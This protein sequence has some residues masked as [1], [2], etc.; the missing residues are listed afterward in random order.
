[1]EKIEKAIEQKK[2]MPKDMKKQV[3]RKMLIGYAVAAAMVTFIIGIRITSLQLEQNTFEW[4]SKGIT[5]A[6]LTLAIVL[7]EI[8]YR[9]SKEKVE[10]TLS[11]YGIETLILAIFTLFIPHFFVEL[12]GNKA[13]SILAAAL[14]VVVYYYV[15]KSIILY[16]L[17]AKRYRKS[18]SDIKEITSKKKR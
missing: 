3:L 18:L 7:F 10:G 16:V 6:A 15:M 2:K 1:M 9:K 17:Q 11:I 5:F 14:F 4:V 12:D 13:N 8:S